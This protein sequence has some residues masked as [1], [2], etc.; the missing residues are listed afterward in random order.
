MGSRT[1]V[2]GREGLV[3][4]GI[5]RYSGREA[6]QEIKYWSVECGSSVVVHSRCVVC[7]GPEKA[8]G[9]FQSRRVGI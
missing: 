9:R 5:S 4:V 2:L 3:S 1:R 6:L 8:M 7:C